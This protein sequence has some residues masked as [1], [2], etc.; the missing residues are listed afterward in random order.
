MIDRAKFF[1][2][3]RNGPFPGRLTTDQ[4]EG[5]DTLLTVFDEEDITDIRWQAYML[6]TAYHETAHT[7]QP[8]AEIGHGRG[9]K[10]GIA[11]NGHVYYG[12]GYVQLTWDYNYNKLGKMIGVDLLHNPDLAMQPDIAAK[13]MLE[14]MIHGTFTGKSL[15]DYFHEGLTDWTNARRIINGT[16][17]AKLIAG[18]A[19]QFY[20]D[21]THAGA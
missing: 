7:M 5:I 12:R 11:I 4:V 8:I 15:H 17:R 18:Y 19:E 10:Y 13:I 6:A 21:L 2:G 9:H 1:E 14:G 20:E 16:D 3:I